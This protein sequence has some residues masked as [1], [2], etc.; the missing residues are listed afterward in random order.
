MLELLSVNHFVN[1]ST[2]RP[3]ICFTVVLAVTE[4]LRGHIERTP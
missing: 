2:N 3:D 1:A 4:N